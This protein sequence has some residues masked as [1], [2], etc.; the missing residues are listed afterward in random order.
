MGQI[1]DAAAQHNPELVR[2]M[3][4]MKDQLLIALIKRLADEKGELT[5][6]VTEVDDTWCAM[7][8]IEVSVEKAFKFKVLKKS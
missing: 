2:L 3:G 5:I 6:P 1:T 8:Q 7:I 4:N